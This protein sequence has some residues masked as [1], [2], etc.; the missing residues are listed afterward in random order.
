MEEDDRKD[1][2]FEVVDKSG[3]RIRLTKERWKHIRLEHPE[4]EDSYEIE[5]VLKNPDKILESDRD[6]SVGWYFTYNKKF[7]E[8]LKVAVK[9]LNGE[10]YVITAH[11]T[12][13]LY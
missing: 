10:G 6:E 13:K 3:R 8:Y 5:K 4:I 7:G 2:I 12:A 9:Y 11:Y 1:V